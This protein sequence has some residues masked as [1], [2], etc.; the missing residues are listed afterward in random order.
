MDQGRAHAQGQVPACVLCGTRRGS[1][2][3]YHGAKDKDLYLCVDCLKSVRR[4]LADDQLSRMT[5]ARLRRHMEV[6]DRLAATYRDSFVAT[7]TFCVGKRHTVPVLEVDEERQLWALPQASMPLAQPVSAIVDIEVTLFADDPSEGEDLSAEVVEGLKLKDLLP[8]VRTFIS[9]L[10]KSRHLDLAPIPEGQ[11]VSCLNLVLTLDDQVAGMDRVEVDLLP[12]M[13]SWPSRVDAGYDCAHDVIAFLKQLASASYERERASLES[14]DLGC[15]DR[16][17]ALAAEGLVSGDE[18]ELLRYYLERMPLQGG[19]GAAGSSYGLVRTVVDAVSEH[20]VFGERTPDLKTQHTVGIE[21]FLGA[22]YRY[23]P[24]LSVGDVVCIMDE[25]RLQSGKGGLL[26]AQDGFAVDD[27]GLGVDD[28]TVLRQPIA[29]DDLLL[30]KEGEKEGG[31]VLVYRD[32]RRVEVNGG[33]YAHFVFAAVNC[34][35]L[36]RTGS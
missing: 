9:S 11:L 15:S 23:A 2:T 10:Y 28:P 16:L 17:C 34:I 33:P 24:G 12:F 5:V 7:K 14:L 35:L 25:T 32:G 26:F 31:L 36:F 30:V 27:F 18:A 29:Y 19:S 3:Y 8:F 20:L 4:S 13:I 21:T 6:R 1:Y 22:F